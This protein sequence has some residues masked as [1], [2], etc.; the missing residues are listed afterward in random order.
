MGRAGGWSRSFLRGTLSVAL[1]IAVSLAGCRKPVGGDAPMEAKEHLWKV[2]RLYK[3]YVER[4]KKG[5]P[6][7]Q[8]L[9]DFGHKLTAEER[10]G[11]IIGE[12]ID[13]L[14]VAPRDKQ[15]YV[16]S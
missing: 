4:N 12:D 3:A 11:Y 16:I 13:G 15:K 7:E 14:F 8:A 6:D 2:F 10:K 1:L 9:R 5:P